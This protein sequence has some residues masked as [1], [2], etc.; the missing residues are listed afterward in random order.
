MTDLLSLGVPN[1]HQARVVLNDVMAGL[2]FLEGLAGV[3][4]ER[5]ALVGH[6][7]GGQLTLLAAERDQRV[8]AV[9]TFRVPAK[10]QRPDIPD[11]CGERLLHGSWARDGG[12]TSP[13]GSVPPAEDVS[14]S[15]QDTR[16]WT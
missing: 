8:R 6:S 15:W 10:D 11:S 12:R 7:F 16:G 4:S 5:I 1:A 14:R 2:S 3:D 9:V 13:I